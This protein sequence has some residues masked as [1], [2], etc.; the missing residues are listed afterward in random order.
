MKTNQVVV[1]AA[2]SLVLMLGIA[3]TCFA[4]QPSD[5]ET[6]TY[7]AVFTS[8]I[9][10]AFPELNLSTEVIQ[11]L[12]SRDIG[13]GEITIAASLASSSGK[14]LDE[15][16]T[17]ADSGFGWGEIAKELGVEPTALGHAV[18]E[19]IGNAKHGHADKD[20]LENAAISDLLASNFGLENSGVAALAESGIKKQDVLMALSA[21]AITGNAGT[22]EKALALRQESRN[23][24]DVFET[25]GIDPRGARDMRTVMQ[26][27][28]IKEQLREMVNELQKAQEKSQEGTG[29][30]LSD[31]N[32]EEGS[33]DQTLDEDNN[34]DDNAQNQETI[35]DDKDDQNKNDKDDKNKD[36]K[37]DQKI[38]KEHKRDKDSGKKNTGAGQDKSEG[39]K[40]EKNERH[41]NERAGHKNGDEEDED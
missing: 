20:A 36:D 13:W 31:E 11:G 26:R 41:N 17:M 14:T 3:G 18:S 33:S 21:A 38:E 15:V 9:I 1:L 7:D 12:R 40:G 4:L 5:T 22:F 28:E 25:L 10:T 24:Q 8:N 37:D 29:T 32:T 35:N 19:V 27:S 6:G 34:N 39:N 2:C 30:E 23:W 16:I